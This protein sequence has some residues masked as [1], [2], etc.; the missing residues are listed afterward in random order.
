MT[1]MLLTALISVNLGV[2]NLLPIPALDG[3][4]IIFN[5]YEL[6]F[7]K[8]PSEAVFTKLTLAGWAI[9]LW[10]MLLGLYND[11][12]RLAGGF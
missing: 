4:H 8:A 7:K 3:G 12:N 1:L 9:L 10:L 5:L 6:I 2:I 11:L